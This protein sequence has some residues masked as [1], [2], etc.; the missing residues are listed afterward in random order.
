LGAPGA[1]QP[2]PARLTELVV[3]ASGSM[4]G[5]L[6]D[7]TV[8]LDAARRAVDALLGRMPDSSIV[9]LRAYG[10][11]SPTERHDCRDTQLL[12]SFG[13]LSGR[14]DAL[15]GA[16]AVLAARGYTPITHALGEAVRDFP[17][18][19]AGEAVIVLVSD[20]KETCKGD[21][22][23][24]ARDL[25]RQNTK[26]VVHTVGFGVDAAARQQLQCVARM[27]GG[28]YFDAATTDE[29]AASLGKA[30]ETVRTIVVERKGPGWL[31]V[32]GADVA[33][34]E[35]ARAE[36][37]VIVGR[38]GHT[39]EAIKLE[40]GL[41]NVSIGKSMWRSVEVEPGRTTVLKP[42]RLEVRHASLA[43]HPIVDRE[44]REVQAQPS[45]S[46]SV[47]ALLPGDYD[48]MFGPVAWPVSLQPGEVKRLDPGVVE[49]RRASINGHAVRTPAGVEVGRPSQTG[50]VL[51]LPPGAYEID[52]GGNAVAFTVVAGERVVFEVR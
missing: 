11:Q 16:T 30:V 31:R 28:R 43:G 21:P 10:H 34:N 5:K 41:Y 37:G 26:L 51:P 20:G 44:T 12:S 15:R 6:P 8:K 29:L 4:A 49:V 40:A 24:L 19:F 9:A 35:V 52:L 23:A 1:A 13:A 17:A 36:T 47:V 22:C 42:A 33:G 48:V 27:A 18:G 25:A 14:R 3:D 32:E 46:Q 45:S 39:Q 38:L 50:S 7:G 2:A